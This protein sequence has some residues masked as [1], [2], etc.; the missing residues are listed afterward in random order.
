MAEALSLSLSYCVAVSPTSLWR[1]RLCGRAT[2]WYVR[3]VLLRR[4]WLCLLTTGNGVTLTSGAWL[5]RSALQGVPGYGD[6]SY[7][8]FRPPQ[9]RHLSEA[10]L[11][12]VSLVRRRLPCFLSDLLCD[13]PPVNAVLLVSVGVTYVRAFVRLCAC[14]SRAA[15]VTL[16]W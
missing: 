1:F 7:R 9:P 8:E 5:V 4:T 6:H 12:A 10:A 3:S 14:T 11:N 15:T 2:G 13:S 16:S